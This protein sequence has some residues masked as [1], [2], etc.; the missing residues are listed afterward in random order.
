MNKSLI[1]LL[2]LLIGL[3]ACKPGATPEPPTAGNADFSTY[4]AV[5]NSLTAGYADGSLYRSGQ[6]ASYPSMLAAQFAMV[7]GGAFTQPLLPGN[8]GW[9]DAKLVLSMTTDCRGDQSL[10]PVP[11][12]GE[13]DRAGSSDNISTQGPFNNVGV[14]GI[15]AIDFVLPVN[16]ASLNPYAGRFFA[17]GQSPMDVATET[18][19]TFFTIWLGNND[20]LGYATAGGGNP[21]PGFLPNNISPLPLFTQAYNALVQAMTANGAKGVLVN[22]PDVTSI[23]FFT[24][25]DP[26]GLILDALQAAQLSAAYSALGISF[27]EGPNPFIIEDASAPGGLRPIQDG[28]YILLTTPGDSLKC[29]GWGSLRPIP[30]NYVLT[31]DEVVAIQDA[32]EGFNGVIQSLANQYDL[33]LVDANAYMG[34]L[35][36]GIK[37]SGLSFSPAFV[38]GGAFSLDGVHLTPRGYALIANEILRV[39]NRRYAATLP[40]IEVTKYNGILFPN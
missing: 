22:I 18:D 23:P 14:P 8:F 13:D 31:H 2:S 5:G 16:Y 35:K 25:I 39:I 26:K 29:G 12:T 33:A 4:V 21:N 34:T 28:E 27:S 10:G 36:R 7:G 1:L 9:P 30:A 19:R 40:E 20:V 11:Y 24:T 37:W 32:T 15:R 38:S 3:S 17:S 6:E